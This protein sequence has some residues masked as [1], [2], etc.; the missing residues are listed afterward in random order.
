MKKSLLFII[1]WGC[2]HKFS[3]A[4]SSY[5][6]SNYAAVGDTFYLTKASLGNFNFDTTGTN[7]TWN[8]ATLVGNSQRRWIYRAPNQTGFTALTWPYIYNSNNVNLSAT[9]GQTIAVGGLQQ[10]NPNDY[11][12]KSNNLLQQKA[13]S[14][15]VVIGS[16]GYNVRNVYTKPDTMYTFP[17]QYGQNFTGNAAYVASIPPNIYYRNVVL[18]RAD[19]VKGWGTVITPYGSFS[20]CLKL[21]SN[22]T[23]I[24][25]IAINDT[26]YT[27]YDTLYSREIQWF[28]PSKKQPVLSV[29]QNRIG[30][31]YITQQIEYL[32]NQIYYP[33]QAL[34]GYFPL[35]PNM[36][37]T[38][39]FQNL[40]T[41]ALSFVWN[42]G[43]PGSG[44]SNTDTEINPTHIFAQPGT[45]NV[46]LIAINGPLRDT[47]ILPIVVNPVN[48]T[49]T[50]NGNGNWSNAA[51]WQNGQVPPTV[52]PSSN[53]IIINPNA[54]GSCILDVTQHV[55]A[56][57][58]LTVSSGKT[59][60]I[61]G[62][63]RVQ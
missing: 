50:F 12:L 27:G 48:L 49:Y 11:F 53:S 7:I 29:K 33:P 59:L 25:S 56:G 34:F 14:Y 9:D 40:S 35:N 38:V 19:T 45:Y 32:D 6:L 51:N 43:D 57:A 31:I 23:T 1:L 26:S 28:D 62:L 39:Q 15:K 4:Q 10:T 61:P 41:N 17:L 13:S 8:Y 60:V 58:S 2:L 18:S 24:D 37:D 3:V 44:A 16:V 52:L 5:T 55:S 54:G 47:I 46:Q 42:F 36:G 21:V 20:N 30:N 22:I 63:L